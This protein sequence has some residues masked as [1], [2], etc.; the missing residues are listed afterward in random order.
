MWEHTDSCLKATIGASVRIRYKRSKNVFLKHTES[1]QL[2]HLGSRLLELPAQSLIGSPG[3][4]Y[5]E[6]RR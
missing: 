6:V 1:S 2:G 5:N 4:P 3:P